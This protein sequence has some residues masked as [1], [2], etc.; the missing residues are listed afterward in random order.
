MFEL[1]STFRGLTEIKR[2]VD[3]LAILLDERETAVKVTAAGRS[4]I[5]AS[6]SAMEE[7]VLSATTADRSVTE[8]KR[9]REGVESR[10][11]A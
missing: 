2:A 9:K 10:R 3:E 8:A 11:G 4:A 7:A 5:P 6:I 1:G